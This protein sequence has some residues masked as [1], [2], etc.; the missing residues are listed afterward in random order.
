MHVKIPKCIYKIRGKCKTLKLEKL[1]NISE[2]W[3]YIQF[4]KSKAIKYN[5]HKSPRLQ[6]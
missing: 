6:N 1:Q 3:N 2:H 4:E 5:L